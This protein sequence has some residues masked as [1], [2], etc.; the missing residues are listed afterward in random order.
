MSPENVEIV[1]RLLARWEDGH[2][3]TD[4]A[5]DPSVEFTRTGG[6]SEVLGY[7]THS[8]GIDGLWG[9]LTAWTDEWSDVHV[10]A[11]SCDE[12]GERVIALVRHRGI[13][14]RSGARMDH[15][16][17]WVFSLRDGRIVRW[18]AYWDPADA[19]RALGFKE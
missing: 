19:E 15:V 13:G 18:D 12:V 11:E 7:T 9:A 2:Y 16:D 6:G 5:F 1:R 14:K 3:D 4:D 10:K 8:R 17:A